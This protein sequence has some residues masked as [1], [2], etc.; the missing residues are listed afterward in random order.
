M[1]GFG[2]RTN[3]I[4]KYFGDMNMGRSNPKDLMNKDKC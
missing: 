2:H 4:R 3:L 1:T